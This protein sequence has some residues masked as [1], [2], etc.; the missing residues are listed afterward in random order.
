MALGC[1]VLNHGLVMVFMLPFVQVAGHFEVTII[2]IALN[3]SSYSIISFEFRV[4][5]SPFQ[6]LLILMMF[7]FF[8][9]LISVPFWALF[10]FDP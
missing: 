10:T 5:W 9:N 4:I 1:F 7:M 3:V 2:F 6:L 8:F